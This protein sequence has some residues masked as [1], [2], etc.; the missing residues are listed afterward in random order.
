MLLLQLAVLALVQLLRDLQ[1]YGTAWLWC[2]V[3]W[4]AQEGIL[5]VHQETVLVNSVLRIRTSPALQYS[6]FALALALSWSL[7]FTRFANSGFSAVATLSMFLALCFGSLS[8]QKSDHALVGSA[9]GYMLLYAISSVTLTLCSF[10]RPKQSL[11]SE[12]ATL[13]QALW[14]LFVPSSQNPLL[15]V[16][17]LLVQLLVSLSLFYWH[18]EHT[19]MLW[20]GFRNKGKSHH[21]G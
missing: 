3:F 1:R 6:L 11:P 5:F 15:T 4:L 9:A 7:F 10:S 18:Q 19:D 20:S 12:F 14:I 17:L 2:W 13:G 8:Q 21:T 16:L